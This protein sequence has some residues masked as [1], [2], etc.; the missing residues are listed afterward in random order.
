[1][2]L[3]S[4]HVLQVRSEPVCAVTPPGQMT[5]SARQTGGVR[6]SIEPPLHTAFRAIDLSGGYLLLACLS[7][8][9]GSYVTD[10]AAKRNFIYIFA[11]KLFKCLLLTRLDVCLRVETEL[12]EAN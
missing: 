11:A 7:A 2:R 12:T 1:M 5:T 8:K 10:T 9:I 4:L 3:L 6:P